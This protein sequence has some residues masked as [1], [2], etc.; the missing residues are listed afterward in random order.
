MTDLRELLREC[1][2]VIDRWHEHLHRLLRN[3]MGDLTQREALRVGELIERLNAALSQ[4]DAAGKS[5]DDS[6]YRRWKPG[7][8]GWHKVKVPTPPA[9]EGKE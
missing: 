2:P 6:F 5:Q 8:S 3:G 4:P 9:G 7:G 1:L